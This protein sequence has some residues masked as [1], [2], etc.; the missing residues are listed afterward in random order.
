MNYKY[1][2]VAVAV[3]LLTSAGLSADATADA[4]QNQAAYGSAYA[5]A[6]TAHRTGDRRITQRQ[7]TQRRF[8]KR[9]G[10][11]A[12]NVHRSE[13]R[14]IVRYYRAPRVYSS[15][16]RYGRHHPR[17]SR[18]QRYH[19]E[20][21]VGAVAAGLILGGIVYEFIRRDTHDGY[22]YYDEH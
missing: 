10:R 14:Q 19:R 9:S 18:Y 1:R 17:V 8:S 16:Y 4:R 6:Q 21:N 22:T 20:V 5:A 2:L 12:R 15:G 11:Y 7:I 13:R 3:G